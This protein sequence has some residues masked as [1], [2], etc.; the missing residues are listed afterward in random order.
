[1]GKAGNPEKKIERLADVFKALADPA[2]L[3]I[4]VLLAKHGRL[5]VNAISVATGLTQPATSQHLKLLRQAG[6]LDA[7]KIG[8]HVHYGID[9]HALAKL[10][11]EWDTLLRGGK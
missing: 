6:I 7:E 9:P 5:C 10:G 11:T 3:S 4:V 8:L 2:R 1:M